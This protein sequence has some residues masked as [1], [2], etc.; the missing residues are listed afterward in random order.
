M[1]E[2][3]TAAD[4]HYYVLDSPLIADFEYDALM[5]ELTALEA[6]NPELVTPASPTQRIGAAPAAAF[7]PVTHYSKMMSLANADSRVQLDTFFARLEKDLGTSEIDY[8]CEPKMDGVAVAITYK[9]GV[10]VRGATRGN[11]TV[12]EDITGNIKTIKSLPLRINGPPLLEVRGEAYITKDQF[13][14][15]NEER[16]NAG[17]P[18]FAN[19]RNAAAGS[20]RQLDPK[21]T[22]ARGLSVVLFAVGYVEGLTFETQWEVLDCFKKLCLPVNPLNAVARSNAEAADFCA[23]TES[24]RHD[25]PYQIDGVVV[26]VDRFDL[27]DRLGATAKS[28]RWAIA[29]KFPPEERTTRLLR[30]VPSV[31]RTGAVTPTALME[32]VDVAGVVVSRATLH[33][34]DEV[35]RKDI[36]EGDWVVVRRAGDVI[37]EVVGPIPA[38]RTG[39]EKEWSLP[40]D[41]PACGGP[42]TRPEGEAVARCTN[43]ACPKQ[44][45]ERL[46][47]F[48]SRSCMDIEGMGPS[49]VGHLLE[50]GKVE[51]IADIYSLTVEDL[52]RIVPHFQD[53]AADNLRAAI[54]QS[55][56]RPLERLLFSLGI[57]HVGARVAELLAREFMEMGRLA[58]AGVEELTAVPEIGR[59]IAQS[60]ADFFA[61]E[62]NRRVIEKLRDA[63]VNMTASAAKRP[64]T[65]PLTG[66]TWVFTGGLE[67]MSRPEA[68]ER[69]EALGGKTASAVSSNTDYV[70]AGEKAG[71]K[72]IKA[73]ELK[74]KILS[75]REFLDLLESAGS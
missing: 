63:G 30:I 27:R 2:R 33:N 60:A 18:A 75:E 73:R 53:R 22:A 37:P 31:G 66:T 12:G 35:R 67:K 65:L 49:V 28:P 40:R 1:R 41:C 20:L 14:D 62:N 4:Y 21:I 54:E 34:E 36:R 46:V 64:E 25:L 59:R 61:V 70:V 74:I 71:T 32:P 23:Q 26:K 16:L 48:G 52:I 3:I 7:P 38:R 57:R 13:R 29:Y 58:Q 44:I 11:G 5:R 6:Q 56:G 72:L 51:D 42:V 39:E 47:H 45:F 50:S 43:I 69:V 15:I 68:A 19:P 8:V 55:K 24:G 17:E 10:Y 9:D